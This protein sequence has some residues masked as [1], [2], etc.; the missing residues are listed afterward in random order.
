[1]AK[2]YVTERA[3]ETWTS[4]GVDDFFKNLGFKVIKLPV[5]MG[6]EVDVPTDF[7]FFAPHLC[8]L[9]GFQ[10]KALYHNGADHWQLSKRQHETLRRFPWIR[11]GFSEVKNGKERLEALQFLRIV[12]PDRDYTKTLPAEGKGKPFYMR[13]PTFYRRLEACT[14]GIKVTSKEHLRSLM[15]AKDQNERTISLA[16]LSVDTFLVDFD[17]SN[18]VHYTTFELERR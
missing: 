16:D 11:Y 5:D 12:D 17:G 18:V 4:D 2:T 3:T 8:K 7:I 10:Y 9:F 15:F 13:W 6:T 1:M 14:E